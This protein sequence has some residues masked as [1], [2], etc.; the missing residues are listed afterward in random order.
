MRVRLHLPVDRL[1]S[2]DEALL[3]YPHR[4]VRLGALGR[5]VVDLVG[6]VHPSTA[7][8]PNASGS[9]TMPEGI[10]LPDLASALTDALGAPPGDPLTFTRDAVVTLVAEGVLEE[11]EP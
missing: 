8:V 6:D 1:D 10:T 5:A 4:V 9:E 7:A 11:V 3:L 2:A